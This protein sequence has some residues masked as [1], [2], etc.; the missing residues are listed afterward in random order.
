[1][2]LSL[3][4]VV[5]GA[6][7][8]FVWI[9]GQTRDQSGLLPDNFLDWNVAQKRAETL[10]AKLDAYKQMC[11]IMTST[12][13]TLERKQITLDEAC[14]HVHQAARETFPTFLRNLRVSEGK[15]LKE[16]I[17]H[18][19]LFYAQM[20]AEKNRNSRSAAALVGRLREEIAGQ[21]FQL[22]CRDERKIGADDA[23]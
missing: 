22:A 19:L 13:R 6:V 9:N 21:S 8:A 12:V 16:K 2:K 3:V 23:Y 11:E 15:T 5:V 7:V 20:N 14:V 10:D 4:L 17:G 1:M 18:K